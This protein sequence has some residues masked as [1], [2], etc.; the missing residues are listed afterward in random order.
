MSHNQELLTLIRNKPVQQAREIAHKYGKSLRVRQINDEVIFYPF[1]NTYSLDVVVRVPYDPM[2]EN[3][4]G[5]K[6]WNPRLK[7]DNNGAMVI[8]IY[9]PE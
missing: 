7:S 6:T 9:R 1:V 8:G 2:L 5:V 3:E 4:D